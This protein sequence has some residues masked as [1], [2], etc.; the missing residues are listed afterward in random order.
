MNVK[1]VLI[2]IATILLI[3]LALTKTVGATQENNTNEIA[4]N[5]SMIDPGA[6]AV[7]LQKTDKP[8]GF[9]AVFA[10]AGLLAV[11]FLVL[12]QRK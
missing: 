7:S 2:I 1:L 6:T 8:P 5:S 10:I 3:L 12:R 11:A 4:A 9:E